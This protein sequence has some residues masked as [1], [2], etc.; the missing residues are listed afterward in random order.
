MSSVPPSA[1]SSDVP[2]D[3][4]GVAARKDF[5]GFARWR[6]SYHLIAS[7][8]WMNDPCAPGYDPSA[9]TYHVGFQWN[10]DCSEWGDIVWGKAFSTDLVAWEVS[11]RP[12]LE[13]DAAYDHAGV[14]TGCWWPGGVNGK[15]KS[16]SSEVAVIYTSVSR[17][18]IHYTLEYHRGCETLSIAV[19]SDGGKSW[20]KIDAN[21]I[22]PGP[23][24][25]PGVTGWRDPYVAH[26]PSM[27]EF[28]R[29][30]ESRQTPGETDQESLFGIISGGIKGKTPTTWLYSIDSKDLTKW[31]YIAP[32]VTPGLN[33]APSRWTGDLGV[34]WEVTNFV[35]L[36]DEQDHTHDFL[37]LG[38]EGCTPPHGGAGVVPDTKRCNR[39]QLWVA[40]ETG[41]P[42]RE[43]TS[44]MKFSYGGIFDHGLFY[45]ANG[46]RDPV[47]KQQ[48][49]IGWV[50]EEDLPAETQTKQGWSGCLSLP[51]IVSLAT[52]E[53]I[54]RASNSSL[55]EITSIKAMPEDGHDGLFKVHTLKITPEPRLQ[56]LRTG[57]TAKELPGV[58]LKVAS[59]EHRLLL[60]TSR[61]EAYVEFSHVG[62]CRR[63]G[64]VIGY[65]STS[66]TTN[67]YFS[68]QEEAFVIDRPD[69]RLPPSH[70]SEMVSTRLQEERAAF[71]LFTTRDAK[72]G[73]EREESLRIHA[74]YDTSVLEVFVNERAV[75][76]TRVYLEDPACSGLAFF[77]EH[78]A[79]VMLEKALAWDGLSST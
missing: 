37:I 19:S 44:L 66:Q 58:P 14:F 62:S 63:V 57:A 11:E 64:I 68:P 38:A 48:I 54:S 26:W 20:R 18:P 69:A 59:Q 28:L 47:S 16:S 29:G 51:R 76:T 21:P 34:N 32:L 74:F 27:G 50:T 10:P 39:A 79:D 24:E 45:A 23:P 36:K 31:K 9:G 60:S 5:Q 75:I 77:A 17:I 15:Q 41:E 73:V 3:Q 40:L 49:V 25:G 4:A 52:I 78:G 2:H 6:P 33:F 72:T 67:L 43:D 12:S 56:K 70:D 13:R 71:T 8:G 42:S 55:R 65:A 53:H 1:S 61:W 30:R 7:S 22:L 35:S 46:F